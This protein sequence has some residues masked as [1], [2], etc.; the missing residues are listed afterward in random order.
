MITSL[1]TVNKDCDCEEPY[2]NFGWLDTQQ[3]SWNNT[4]QGQ[5]AGL[6]SLQNTGY[7]G[8]LEFRR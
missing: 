1:H 6:L 4:K 5:L 2:V 8:Q 3:V 7:S